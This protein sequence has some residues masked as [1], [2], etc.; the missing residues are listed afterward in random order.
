M[1]FQLVKRLNHRRLKIRSGKKMSSEI[2]AKPEILCV[3][4]N[5]L[6]WA[7]THN[8]NFIGHLSSWH[9]PTYLLKNSLSFSIKTPPELSEKI[10]SAAGILVKPIAGDKA[11]IEVRMEIKMKSGGVKNYVGSGE[12]IK[13]GGMILLNGEDKN[14]AFKDI[15]LVTLTFNQPV[16]IATTNNESMRV[17]M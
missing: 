7:Y 15:S 14:I 6:G 5:P 2:D 10:L 9:N 3:P 8:C 13:S 11:F 16:E 1:E 4:I 17:M 12:I